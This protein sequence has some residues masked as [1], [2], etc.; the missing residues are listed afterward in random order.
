[1]LALVLLGVAFVLAFVAASA[2]AIRVVARVGPLLRD[3]RPPAP[4]AVLR[5]RRSRASAA[6]WPALPDAAALRPPPPPGAA[7][8]R[9]PT[10]AP[11]P[12]LPSLPVGFRYDAIA[13]GP[14]QLVDADLPTTKVCPDCAETVLASARVCKHC[15]FRFE[16]PLRG[17][18]AV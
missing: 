5:P 9:P 18:W 15:H 7:A 8:L 14:L 3:E 13:P 1:M 17:S 12:E 16:P 6:R 11:P 10:P 2:V 4:V